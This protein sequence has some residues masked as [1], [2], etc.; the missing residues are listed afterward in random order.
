[1]S[2]TFL[3]VNHGGKT[4]TVALFDGI[5][6]EEIA[7]ILRTVFSTSG[8]IVGFTA[9]V[10]CICIFVG[11]FII[12]VFRME[13]FSRCQLYVG[14]HEVLVRLSALYWLPNQTSK[15]LL[16]ADLTWLKFQTGKVQLLQ[17]TF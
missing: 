12:F 6:T 13:W 10:I 14:H 15:R 16:Q 7:S 9:E 4:Q 3:K 11:C 8:S 2:T 5:S 17:V 1:M